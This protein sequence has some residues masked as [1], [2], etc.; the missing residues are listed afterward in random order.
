M[1]PKTCSLALD[2]IELEEQCHNECYEPDLKVV[3]NKRLFDNPSSDE[4]IIAITGRINVS[5]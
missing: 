2:E 3:V 5:F 4:D 1:S